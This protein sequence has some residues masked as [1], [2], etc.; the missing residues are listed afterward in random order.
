MGEKRQTDAGFKQLTDCL[1]NLSEK[2]NI[3]KMSF[4]L[5]KWNTFGFV[6]QK[7]FEN[8]AMDSEKNYTITIYMN[9]K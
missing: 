3:L 9:Q 5:Y 4:F 8:V 1:C 6:G 2:P 7:Q